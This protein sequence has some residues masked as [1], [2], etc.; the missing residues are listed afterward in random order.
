MP[1]HLQR[2]PLELGLQLNI[3]RLI[4]DGLVQPGK[5]TQ[6]SS[7]RWLDDEGDERASA[8]IAADLTIPS[9]DKAR[10]GKMRIHAAWINQ[11]VQLV[12]RPRHFGGVQ[13]YFVCPAQGKHVSVLWA[14]PR[15]RYFVGRKALGKQVAYLSQYH[16]PGARANYSAEKLIKRTWGPDASDELPKPKWM[17][18]RTYERLSN[19]LQKFNSEAGVLPRLFLLDGDVV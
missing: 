14:M 2:T 15:T 1:R 8:R 3:N 18:W 19:K 11:T 10:S 13:W 5:V 12:G 9:A 6:P 7:F 16:S 4:R 17:R